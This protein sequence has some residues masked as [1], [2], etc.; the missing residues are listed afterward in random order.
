MIRVL[1]KEKTWC[2]H[3]KINTRTFHVNKEHNQFQ[4]HAGHADICEKCDKEK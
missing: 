2:Q 3:C 4:H 1:T